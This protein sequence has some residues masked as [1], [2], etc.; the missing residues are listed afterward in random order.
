MAVPRTGP[1]ATK[2]EAGSDQYIVPALRRGLELLRLFSH[3]RRLV[4]LPE[5]VRE[6]GVSRA[7][8]YRLAY[9]LEADGYLQREPHSTAFRL[10]INL[11]S[12]GFEYLGSL[13]LVEVARP[14]VEELRDR[15]DASAHIGVQDGIEVVYVLAAPSRHHLRS[16]ITAGARRL[17]HASSIGRVLMFDCS[18]EEL[19]RLFQ[20]VDMREQFPDAPADAEALFAELQQQRAAGWVA[21]RSR[22]ASGLD[23]VAAPVRDATGTIV[24][25]VNISDYESIPVMKELEG[26]LKDEVLRA[27]MAISRG[28]GYRPGAGSSQA[29]QRRLTATR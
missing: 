9:T 23:S 18:L 15:V 6:L 22:F 12:L 4:T 5:I 1:K 27:A 10:G 16:N 3:G 25:G 14:V 8:A 20:K 13:D 19:R 29:G 11:L 7:T 2:E 26:R 17:M 24:A 21:Y 28:L